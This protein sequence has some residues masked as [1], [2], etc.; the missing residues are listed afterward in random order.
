MSSSMARF[1]SSISKELPAW[2]DDFQ[3]ASD[4]YTLVMN[5]SDYPPLLQSRSWSLAVPFKEQRLYHTPS[6]SIANNYTPSASN[7]KIRYLP[8][9]GLLKRQNTT[10]GDFKLHS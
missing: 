5:N 7:L 2:P 4:L 3:E 9:P 1:A 6:E 10:I 8:K